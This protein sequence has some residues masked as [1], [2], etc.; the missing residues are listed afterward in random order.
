MLRARKYSLLVILLGLFVAFLLPTGPYLPVGAVFAENVK[1]VETTEDTKAAGATSSPEESQPAD[2]LAEA[3]DAPEA[4]DAPEADVHLDS[5]R[6]TLETF[7]NAYHKEELKRTAACFDFSMVNPQP[8]DEVKYEYAEK[9]VEIINRV[10]EVDF[11]KVSDETE[12]SRYLWPPDAEKQPV[13]IERGEDGAW[14][15]AAYMTARLKNTFKAYEEKPIVIPWYKR[16]VFG[17]ELW[18]FTKIFLAL[19]VAWIIGRIVKSTLERSGASLEKRNREYSSTMFHSLAKAAVPAAL[20]CGL[21]IGMTFLDLNDTVRG[22]TFTS[23][24]VL[25][26]LTIAYALYCLVD[27]IA[28]WLRHFSEKTHSKLDDMLA[29][30]VTTSAR[31][32]IVVLALVQIATILSDKPMTSVIAGLGVGGLA[33]GL[34]AQDMIKNFFGSLMIFTDQPF[35]LGDRVVISDTDG[36]VESVGFRSTR[37]RTLDGHLVTMP[38]GD[39]ANSSV[40]NVTARPNIKRSF[41]V[42]VTYDTPPEKVQQGI[43]ILHEILEDHEG[44]DADTPARIYFNDMTD[45]ALSI[46]VIYWYHPAD[47]WAYCEFS[48]RVNF[49]ILNRFNAEGIEFAFPTQTLFLAGDS[50]RP[51]TVA[52]G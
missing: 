44:M 26:T 3:P 51:L 25:F 2:R 47:Y 4:A 7:W 17:N 41:S 20:V 27:V 39:V 31:A 49:E 40:R 50:N 45:I 1:V 14:R 10:A 46:Q 28:V 13:V 16:M 34:A 38:N 19:L 6:A 21:S 15:F 23:T 12:G 52:G 11:T 5:P 30:M 32:A 8:N 43:D 42:T 35:E 36:I 24:S 18:E 9:L 33:I 48:Q 37:I 29:P 22:I